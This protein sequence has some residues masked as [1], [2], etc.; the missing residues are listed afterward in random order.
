[1]EQEPA[2]RHEITG[3]KIKR[4]RDLMTGMKLQRGA[5]R[6]HVAYASRRVHTMLRMA[7]TARRARA[8]ERDH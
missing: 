5:R 4:Q 1:M 6:L 2:A 3:A 8:R 7:K